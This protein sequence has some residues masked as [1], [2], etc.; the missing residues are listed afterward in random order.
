MAD[1]ST[2][3]K[4][5]IQDI[6][7]ND[8]SNEII[9]DL[10]IEH[11]TPEVQAELILGIGQTVLERLV[12]EIYKILPQEAHAEADAFLDA[13]DIAG[14][15]LLFEKHIPDFDA[16]VKHHIS[17]ELEKIK[18]NAQKVSQGVDV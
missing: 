9:T 17:I 16:F 12:L 8:Y 10:G 13:G 18:S 6:L 11:E 5:D 7:G 4:K 15:R 3:E 2:D 14:A 1:K